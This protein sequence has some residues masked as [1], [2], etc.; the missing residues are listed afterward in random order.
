MKRAEINAKRKG[1]RDDIEEIAGKISELEAKG[2]DKKELKELKKQLRAETKNLRKAF[3][4]ENVLIRKADGTIDAIGHYVAAINNKRIDIYNDINTQLEKLSDQLDM[5]RQQGR[6]GLITMKEAIHKTM[7]GIHSA[8]EK[9]F[10]NLRDLS[11]V[12][13]KRAHGMTI[14]SKQLEA[15]AENQIRSLAGQKLRDI[16]SETEKVSLREKY[17][18]AKTEALGKAADK[19]WQKGATMAGTIAADKAEKEKEKA[20]LEKMQGDH[21]R[22]RIER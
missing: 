21:K 8:I 17:H 3:D 14:A 20:K 5:A 22:K 18:H 7:L 1:I 12:M 9:L 2:G 13:E 11:A 4:A 6:I 16:P 19:A 15:V 10:T